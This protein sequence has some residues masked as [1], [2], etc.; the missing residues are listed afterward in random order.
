MDSSNG[1]W[2]EDT[3]NPDTGTLPWA[4]LDEHTVVFYIPEGFD[5]INLGSSHY[6]ITVKERNGPS[7]DYTQ[8]WF[9][10]QLLVEVNDKEV[11]E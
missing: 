10:A 11:F 1:S 7:N 9:V 5:G 3:S 8:N 2:S 4:L 6:I